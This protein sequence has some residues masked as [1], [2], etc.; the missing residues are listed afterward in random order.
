MRHSKRKF[1]QRRDILSVSPFGGS[2]PPSR[3]QTFLKRK[4]DQRRFP[5]LSAASMKEVHAAQ[6]DKDP[7]CGGKPAASTTYLSLSII[8][9]EQW[10]QW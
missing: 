5:W 1:N 9:T 4:F 6:Q 3:I 7:A 8:V 2:N 10:C